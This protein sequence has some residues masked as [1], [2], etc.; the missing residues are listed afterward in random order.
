MN[1]N[2]NTP[3]TKSSIGKDPRQNPRGSRAERLALLK[4]QSLVA[5]DAAA[6]VAKALADIAAVKTEVPGLVAFSPLDR[7]RTVKVPTGAEKLIDKMFI[8]ARLYPTLVPQSVDTNAMSDTLLFLLEVRTLAAAV[9]ELN[10]I[11]GDTVY[12][13]VTGLWKEALDI[14]ASLQRESAAHPELEPVLA[15]MQAFLARTPA[16]PAP[17]TGIPAVAPVAIVAASGNGASAATTG[18]ASGPDPSANGAGVVTH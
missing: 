3:K 5:S 8:A 13:R 9:A 7:I 14:Y 10:K 11:V 15:E 16:V 6:A 1:T 17:A 2:D 12:V 4:P 18:T